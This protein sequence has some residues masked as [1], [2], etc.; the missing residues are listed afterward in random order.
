MTYRDDYNRFDSEYRWTL[1]RVI[2]LLLITIIA[3]TVLGWAACAIG[4]V[5][6]VANNAAAVVPKEL[7]PEALLRKYEWFKDASAALDKKQADIQ[8]YDGRIQRMKADYVGVPRAKW[9]RDEREQLAIWESE[10]SGI[11]ASY[12]ALAAE[13]NAEMSK[14]NWRFTNVGDVPQGGKPVPREFRAYQEQ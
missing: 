11:K 1:P 4:L 5:G 9:P 14:I 3:F 10:E 13:Y 6:G 8:V 7:Y 12:N 2:G